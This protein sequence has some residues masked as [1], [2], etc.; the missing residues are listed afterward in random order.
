MLLYAGMAYY[1]ETFTFTYTDPRKIS[2]A[3]YSHFSLIQI[4]EQRTDDC[5][6]LLKQH[7]QRPSLAFAAAATVL[8]V[9]FIRFLGAPK[10]AFLPHDPQLLSL[11]EEIPFRKDS[12]T[13]QAC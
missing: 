10:K 3:G 13:K 7:S 12:I 2:T 6:M 4:S 8:L 11:I 9:T 1:G 5:G